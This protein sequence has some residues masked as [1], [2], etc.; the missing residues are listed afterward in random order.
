MI[1]LF[2]I[3]IGLIIGSF[4]NVCIYRMPKLK[5]IVNPPSHCP[6]CEHIIPWYDNIPVIS[7]LLLRGRCRFCKEKISLRYIIVELLTVSV[8]VLMVTTLGLHITT[9][10]FMVLACGMIVAAFI[11]FKY[12][13]I[14]DEI[15]CGG[16]ALGLI[17]SLVFP[18]L[19]NTTSRLKAV[20]VS[21]LGLLTGGILIYLTGVIGKL[22]F[23]KEA[24]GGGD[25]KLLAM[26]G[27]F[28]GFKNIIF[29]YFLAPFFGSV[30]GIIMKLK[31]KV[32]I[33]PYGP[34]LS[35]A[36]LVV[37]LWGD[38]ILRTLFPY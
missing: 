34:Y 1:I 8:F 33:I 3:I 18:Q 19:H 38:K 15:T 12:Q 30:V 6:H 27:S 10:V 4:L 23:K 29:I 35:L 31:Y 37:I 20:S 25:V 21:G 26:I 22:M 13:I 11:D 16:M 2:T 36:S 32:D 14:P 17:F 28:V 9:I 7:F 24:M 5:S